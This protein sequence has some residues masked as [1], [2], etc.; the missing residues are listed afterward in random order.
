[1]DLLNHRIGRDGDRRGEE[2]VR[3]NDRPQHAVVERHDDAQIGAPVCGLSRSHRRDAVAQAQAQVDQARAQLAK[4]REGGTK[5]DIAA[6]Q[7]TVD[8]MQANVA[9]LTAPATETDLAIQRAAV[10]QAQQA[11]NQAR[12]DLD[13][14]T[15]IA[16]FGGVVSMVSIIS[17][18]IVPPNQPV[19]SLV[20][21]SRLFVDLKLSETDI[22]QVRFNQ[23]VTMT[24][25]AMPDWQGLGKV[26]HIAP[27]AENTN[28]VVTYEVES[29]FPNVDARV[30]VGMTAN[31]TILTARKDNVLIVPNTALLPKGT[32]HVVQVVGAD[33]RTHEVP[34]RTGLTDGKQN[35]IVEGLKSGN[36]VVTVP[37]SAPPPS[38][39]GFLNLGR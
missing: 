21:R 25:D 27:A 3:P 28:G 24:I 9:R 36:Q 38:G 39:G 13:K 30:R 10:A 4:L 34:V 20:D 1:M 5:A 17:G 15:L 18:S 7:A 6:A 12:L 22:V 16:P 26:T 23:P 37:L 8:Q 29:S 19:V 31:L 2:R 33:G 32:G 14:A 35:E 11:L